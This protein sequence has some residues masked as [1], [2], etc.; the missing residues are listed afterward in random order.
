MVRH[1]RV[2]RAH[3]GDAVRVRRGFGEQLA[4]FQSTLAV[5]GEFEWRWKGRAGFAFGFV[6]GNRQGFVGVGLEGGFGVEGIDVGWAAVEEE[7]DDP[8]GSGG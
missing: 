2:H 7:V 8:F 4:D 3:H 5:P 6:V 1:L